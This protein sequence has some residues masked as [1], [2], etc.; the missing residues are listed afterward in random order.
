MEITIDNEKIKYSGDKNVSKIYGWNLYVPGIRIGAHDFQRFNK[1]YA[2]VMLPEKNIWVF[3]RTAIFLEVI[4]RPNNKNGEPQYVIVHDVGKDGPHTWDVPKGQV[5]YKEFMDIK[6]KFR[7]PQTGLRGLLKEGI[8]REL[9]EESRISLDDVIGLKELTGLVV[10]G[11]HK[12][13]PKNF[14]YQYHLFEGKVH[15]SLFDKAKKKVDK[16]RE[17]PLLTIN[18]PKDIIEKDNIMLWSPSDGLN[19]ILHGDPE[20]IVRLYMSYKHGLSMK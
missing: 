15:Y 7:T 4:G 19:K 18:M 11:K 14:H 5:E 2:Y 10:A 12:D 17:N 20:K 8:R 13:L 9:E 1:Q 16:L 3:L 6:H